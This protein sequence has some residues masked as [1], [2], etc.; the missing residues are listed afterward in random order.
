MKLESQVTN[1]ELSKKLKELGVKQESLYVWGSNIEGAR[2]SPI[3][4]KDFILIGVDRR[5]EYPNIFNFTYS[6]FTAS[7][8]GDI[9]PSSIQLPFKMSGK[10]YWSNEKGRYEVDTETNGRAKMLI[11]LLEHKVIVL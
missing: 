7:E 5:G 6:A 4:E 2:F 10:W 3:K 9:F 11:Y 1:L 8:L